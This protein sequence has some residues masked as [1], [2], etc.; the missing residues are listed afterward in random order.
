MGPI[1][2]DQAP[3]M[4]QSRQETIDLTAVLSGVKALKTRLPKILRLS[5]TSVPLRKKVNL[6][7]A[8]KWN[9]YSAAAIT[10]KPSEVIQE[11]VNIDGFL[12]RPISVSEY[13]K[14][15]EVARE[16]TQTPEKR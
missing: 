14:A 10:G 16:I 7:F 9:L 11:C 6:K 15:L 2:Q 8:G 4:T 3:V 13:Q 5:E 1:F 12:P